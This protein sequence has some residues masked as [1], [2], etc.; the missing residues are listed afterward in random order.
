M[1]THVHAVVD[2]TTECSPGAAAIVIRPERITLQHRDDAVGPGHNAISGT[3]RE[4]VYLGAATQVH[5]DVGQSAALVVE[6]PNHAGPQSVRY[7]PGSP[8]TCVCTADAVR[9][10]ARSAAQV[11]S[12][13]IA[14]QADVLTTS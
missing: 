11:V 1:S 2:P 9:V 7:A 6:I 12:D 10:L 14:E 3:V 8:V 13:P 5:V 4:T